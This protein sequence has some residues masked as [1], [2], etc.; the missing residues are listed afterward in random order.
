MNDTATVSRNTAE[1]VF[2]AFSIKQPRLAAK[3]HPWLRPLELSL[4]ATRQGSPRRPI[5][6]PGKAGDMQAQD[7]LELV[8]RWV[9]KDLL[10][11]AIRMVEEEGVRYE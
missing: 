4:A 7:I 6:V 10:E 2:R 11:A 3:L 9:G 5:Q 8:S 1:L